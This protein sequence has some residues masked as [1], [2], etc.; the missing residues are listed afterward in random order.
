MT[1]HRE[2]GSGQLRMSRTAEVLLNWATAIVLGLILGAL[3]PAG[4]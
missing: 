3:P 2:H 4:F 1:H